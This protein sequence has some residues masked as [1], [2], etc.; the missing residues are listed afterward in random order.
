VY[1]GTN[2]AWE[3]VAVSGDIAISETGATTIQANSV[4]LGTDTTGDY[5]SSLGS[6]TGLSTSGNSGEGST[7][8][9]SVLYGNT[10]NTAVQGNTQITINNGTNLTGGGTII[11]GSGGS[12]TLNVADSPTFSGTLTVQG[13]SAT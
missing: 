3:N 2:S 5:I 6:L 7:P 1:N 4:A 9:L 13:A 12:V 8:T 10:A 11:L